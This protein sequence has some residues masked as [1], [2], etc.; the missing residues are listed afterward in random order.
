MVCFGQ[1][2]QVKR[3]ICQPEYIS[4]IIDESFI[5]LFQI[6]SYSH[7]AIM[8]GLNSK[9]VKQLRVPIPPLEEQKKIISILS[10]LDN[11]IQ[12]EKSY[13]EKLKNLKKGLM[14]DL[15]TGKVRVN[16]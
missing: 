16:V 12:I 4:K 5:V 9:I 10:S 2:K 1:L 8:S 13:K 15:L 6:N 7:G 3:E 14:Q 11:K